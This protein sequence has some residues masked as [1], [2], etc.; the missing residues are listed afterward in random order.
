MTCSTSI[1]TPIAESALIASRSEP[2]TKNFDEKM[3]AFLVKQ[4]AEE[5]EEFARQQNLI[6][7]V[8]VA[9]I[10]KRRIIA[11]AKAAKAKPQHPAFSTSADVLDY[12]TSFSPA[13]L[14][15]RIARLVKDQG[16][17]TMIDLIGL[18]F[19][20]DQIL[21]TGIA[22]TIKHLVDA[23]IFTYAYG[24][25]KLKRCRFYRVNNEC[26]LDALLRLNVRCAK[27]GV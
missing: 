7:Q 14:Y 21:R 5:R 4:A 27:V 2:N 22:A 10:E 26:P 15:C 16:P 23:G 12:V 24:D 20:E 18:L 3:R 11:E 17:V 19:A 9:R 6:I 13:T 1:P 8:E 25:G